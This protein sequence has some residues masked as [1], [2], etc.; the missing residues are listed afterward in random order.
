MWIKQ[1]QA[2]FK[3]R[4]TP[5]VSL[6]E[7]PLFHTRLALAPI[8]SNNQIETNLR[9]FKKDSRTC[10]ILDYRPKKMSKASSLHRNILSLQVI[11]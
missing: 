4:P 3:L 5:N 11:S 2:G 8:S 1:R 10:R 9:P 7:H 6:F